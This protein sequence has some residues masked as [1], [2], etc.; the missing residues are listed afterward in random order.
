M[1]IGVL[2]GIKKEAPRTSREP[3]ILSSGTDFIYLALPSPP[4]HP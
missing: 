2:W 4:I 1:E 3:V